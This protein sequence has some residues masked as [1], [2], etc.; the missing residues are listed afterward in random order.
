MSP[1]YAVH[2]FMIKKN[3][4]PTSYCALLSYLCKSVIKRTDLLMT[5][6]RSLTHF[7]CFLQSFGPVANMNETVVMQMGCITRALPF[8]D[9]EKL[10]FLLETLEGI[11]HCGWNESQVMY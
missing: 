9:L 11:G 6:K 5:Q 10:P 1:K 2:R 3:L 8:P 4:K 7:L